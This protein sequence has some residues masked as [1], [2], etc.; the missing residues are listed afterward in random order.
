MKLG[1]RGDTIVEVL[2]AVAIVGVVL[3]GA[4]ASA[5]RSLNGV[6]ASQERAEALK[7]AEG[8]LE[9]LKYYAATAPTPTYPAPSFCLYVSGLTVTTVTSADVT[10]CKN[11]NPGARY[12]IAIAKDTPTTDVFTIAITW[13]QINGGTGQLS[14]GYKAKI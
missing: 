14:I 9:M 12:N 4:Y 10:H 3:T 7:I 8:Q 1:S 13:P 2:I 11:Q 5:R 6:R